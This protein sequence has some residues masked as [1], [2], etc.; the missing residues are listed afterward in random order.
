[1]GH[2]SACLTQQP[3]CYA[4]GFP[5]EANERNSNEALG[6]SI[7]FGRFMSE[8]LAWEKWSTFSQNRYVEEAERFTQ[9]GSVAQKKAF[10]EAHY[11]KLAAQKAA[12][13]LEQ[14]TSSSQTQQEQQA[15]VD[16]T[17]K[18]HMA[19]PISRV[20]LREENAHFFNTYSDVTATF[21]SNS[22]TQTN[23][24]QSNKVEKVL[25]DHQSDYCKELS[26]EEGTNFGKEVLQPMGK[27]KQPVS[28]FK[29]LKIVG[30]SKFNNST[31][32]KCS[33]PSLSNK[34]DIATPMSNK[35]ANKE[36]S[37]AKSPHMSL[38]FT[39]IREI[40]RLT[41]SL[42]TKFEST[43]VGA[44]S[45]KTSK[46]GSTLLRTT[47]KVS[48]N[49]LQKHSPFTPLREAERS[50]KTS[51]FRWRT[52]ERASS[53]KKKLE[54]EFSGS[55]VQ[56]MRLHTKFKEKT[57]INIR[58]LRQSFCFKARSPPDLYKDRE[59]SRGGTK[60]DGLTP[61]ESTNKGK[62]PLSI[63]ESPSSLHCNRPLQGKTCGTLT[64]S[65]SYVI[66][67]HE[68]TSPNIQNGN[69]NNRNYKYSITV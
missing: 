53:R 6:Q 12:A 57:E 44:D 37:T 40:N 45:S 65:N 3:F 46:D 55:E 69:Q 22:N 2:S 48:K 59:A 39:L 32:V 68:N 28:S 10:F 5:K 33:T 61:P 54:K 35:S 14:A 29:L 62:R 7:S 31:P 50:K 27:K 13:L 4:S 23:L 18:S 58:K 21:K 47:T 26:E 43:R 66:T 16:N 63:A 17:H 49:E 36:K 24:P 42:M 38:N 30:S 15:A 8:S 67:T 9:P 25:P 52:E 51:P 56:K 1:M 64:N 34:D 20:V 11:K 60:M 41:V 19:S